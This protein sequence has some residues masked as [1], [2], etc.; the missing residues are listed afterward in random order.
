ME[1]KFTKGEWIYDGLRV[2]TGDNV[3]CSMYDDDGIFKNEKSNAKLI[4]AAPELLFALKSLMS[5]VENLPAL[6]SISGVLEKQYKQAER[7][8]KKA[9]E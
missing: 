9:T 1:T 5:G 4:A 2:S 7:A 6:S 3:I 8:I